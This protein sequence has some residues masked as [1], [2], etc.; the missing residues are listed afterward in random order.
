MPW[1]KIKHTRCEI[2]NLIEANFGRKV[3]PVGS[4][5]RCDFS[6]CEKVWKL[7]AFKRDSEGYVTALD[8]E[9]DSDP[10]AD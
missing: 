8:W 10:N 7:V 6:G 2:P 9:L 3:Q 1:V 4:T 5:Y